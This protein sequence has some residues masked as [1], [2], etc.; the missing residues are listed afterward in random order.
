[1]G[2]VVGEPALGVSL[3]LSRNLVEVFLATVAL[4]GA[5]FPQH[6]LPHLRLGRPAL[7]ALQPQVLFLEEEQQPLCLSH[8]EVQ[9]EF[10]GVVEDQV[11]EALCLQ[12]DNL[13][14]HQSLEEEEAVE[15]T[16]C[17]YYFLHLFLE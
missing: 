10:L 5:F 16:C 13:E 17:A 12:V 8:L 1:M 4:V 9:E 6:Q 3:G 2:V 11:E 7:L 14:D 15:L